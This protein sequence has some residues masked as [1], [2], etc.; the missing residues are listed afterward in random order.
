MRTD[1]FDYNLKPGT[2]PEAFEPNDEPRQ[3][4]DE[5]DAIETAVEQLTDAVDNALRDLDDLPDAV[6]D[7]IRDRIE[8][9]LDSEAIA[10]AVGVD[11][12]TSRRISPKAAIGHYA[13]ARRRISDDL[14]R[15]L[16]IIGGDNDR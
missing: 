6:R 7:E 3:Y 4:E 16:G 8:T 14:N 12:P 10:E 2:P 13:E 11:E 1:R 5:R 9:A 15:A